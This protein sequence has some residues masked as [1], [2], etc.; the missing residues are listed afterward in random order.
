MGTIQNDPRAGAAFPRV[1]V[2]YDK[3]RLINAAAAR[4]GVNIRG[5]RKADV[6]ILHYMIT[7]DQPS[8]CKEITQATGLGYN[9]VLNTVKEHVA[10]G[11]YRKAPGSG[12][13]FEKNPLY[14]AI[15]LFEEIIDLPDYTPPPENPPHGAP[16]GYV[17]DA[18]GSEEF[19][20]YGIT[21]QDDKEYDLA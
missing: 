13:R 16:S 17:L 9:T 20:V 15:R 8:N 19:N 21:E 18:G 4:R 14:S 5:F 12:G 11:L 6:V 3:I 7:A 2:Y 10:L 1:P